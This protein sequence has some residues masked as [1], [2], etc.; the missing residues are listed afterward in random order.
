MEKKAICL[1]IQSAKVRKQ[2]A[3]VSF[4][5]N[6]AQRVFRT[7]YCADLVLRG[8]APPIWLHPTLDSEKQL[9]GKGIPVI[10]H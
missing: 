8:F 4:G 3:Q 5:I 10:E 7:I 6:F 1:E 2:I 9:V